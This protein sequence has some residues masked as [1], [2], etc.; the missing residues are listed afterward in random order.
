MIHQHDGLYS[1]ARDSGLRMK[2]KKEFSGILRNLHSFAGLALIVAMLVQKYWVLLNMPVYKKIHRWIGLFILSAMCV[3]A[4]AGYYL[5]KDSEFSNFDNFSVL[6]AF[7]WI[8]WVF[9]IYITIVVYK[10]KVWHN[11]FADMAFKGC[12]AVPLARLS[13]TFLQK[14]SDLSD[15]DGFYGGIAFV[16]VVFTVWQGWDL[17]K[18]IS[19]F[20][21]K[22][23]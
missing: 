9:A 6:F 3:M 1:I 14:F 4:I 17:L 2:I 22:E 12:L 23:I 15:E 20:Q 8:F 18:L 19:V 21:K 10:S 5:G 7:P 16:S 11:F 13:G